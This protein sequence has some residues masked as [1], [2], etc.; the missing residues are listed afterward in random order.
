MVVTLKFLDVWDKI[1]PTSEKPQGKEPTQLSRLDFLLIGE[2]AESL[3]N[4]A[5]ETNYLHLEEWSKILSLSS[6]KPGKLL[7]RMKKFLNRRLVV[8]EIRLMA[9]KWDHMKFKRLQTAKQL[10][11]WETTCRTR[12]ILPGYTSDR[13]IVSAIYKDLSKLSKKTTQLRY[14]IRKRRVF[15]KEETW[16]WQ[17]RWLGGQR[18]LLCRCEGLNP[19]GSPAVPER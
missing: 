2:R 4:G 18:G 7:K 3:T 5:G 10:S 8:C 1:Y 16:T 14:R 13:K 11:E 12:E 17:L 6:F 15:P 19:H 9:N